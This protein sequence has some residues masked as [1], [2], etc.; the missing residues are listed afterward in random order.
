MVKGIPTGQSTEQSTAEPVP[1]DPT[2][3]VVGLSGQTGVANVAQQA[4]ASGQR[5]C[6]RRDIPGVTPQKKKWDTM[7][8]KPTP[9]QPLV[10]YDEDLLLTPH[11]DDTYIDLD[12]LEDLEGLG[13]QTPVR[14]DA[15]TDDM[16]VPKEKQVHP[17]E[18]TKSPPAEKPRVEDVQRRLELGPTIEASTSAQQSHALPTDNELKA[19]LRSLEFCMRMAYSSQEMSA[20]VPRA[21]SLNAT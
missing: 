11:T 18:H 19:M 13:R 16:Q 4:E 6:H 12:N 3:A 7:Q 9:P 2:T 21:D 14:G 10:D 20:Q 8:V 17:R 1:V 5:I 15:G